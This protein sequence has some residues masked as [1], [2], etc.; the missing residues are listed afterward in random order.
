MEDYE[1][2]TVKAFRDAYLVHG[3]QFPFIAGQSGAG[4]GVDRDSPAN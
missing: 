1:V 2:T 4:A 3:G